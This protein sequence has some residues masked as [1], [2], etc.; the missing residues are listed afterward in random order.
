[1]SF[2]AIFSI[3]CKL[4]SSFRCHIVRLQGRKSIFSLKFFSFSNFQGFFTLLKNYQKIIVRS[5]RR[6][7]ESRNNSEEMSRWTRLFFFWVFAFLS[8]KL[9]K[10]R[11]K[12]YWLQNV[13]KPSKNSTKFK[14]SPF[15]EQKKAQ[16]IYFLFYFSLQISLLFQNLK[17]KKKNPKIIVRLTRGRKKGRKKGLDKQGKS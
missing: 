5:T 6:R 14:P 16:S 8:K 13:E 10:I 9:E 15:T 11:K 4:L 1:M 7:K 3:I 2:E 17:K 12:K